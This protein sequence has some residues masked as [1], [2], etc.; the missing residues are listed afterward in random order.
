MALLIAISMPAVADWKKEL[1]TNFK[2]EKYEFF[3]KKSSNGASLS[4]DTKDK[5][6]TF[7]HPRHVLNG[8]NGIKIDGIYYDIS[9][10][11][12]AGDFYAISICMGARPYLVNPYYEIRNNCFE[13]AM[14]ASK[15]EVNVDYY[16]NGTT[17]VTF[18]IN[19]PLATHKTK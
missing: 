6:L 1:V 11:T 13:A 14:T 9:E 15:I 2:G 16:Q 5:F 17:P 19:K 3:S 4:Y 10:K 7:S 18:L 12:E 8:V